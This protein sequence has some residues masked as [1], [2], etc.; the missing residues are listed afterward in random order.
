ERVSH[1]PV[2]SR[3]EER[4]LDDRF[5][6]QNDLTAARQLVLSHVRFVLHI[7]R[8]YGGYGLPVGDLIQEGN[9]GL[10]KAVKRFDPSLNVRLVSVSGHWTRAESHVYA[11]RTW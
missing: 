11:L 8:G 2:L 10:M 5:K 3:E 4:A 6:R 7:A 9:V 1:I